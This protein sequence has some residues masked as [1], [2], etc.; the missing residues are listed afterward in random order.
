MQRTFFHTAFFKIKLTLGCILKQDKHYSKS[1]KDMAAKKPKS[2]LSPTALA[3]P[4]WPA[5]G[6][7]AAAIIVSIAPAAKPSA[8]IKQV[9]FN[10]PAPKAVRIE[11][12]WVLGFVRRATSDPMGDETALRAPRA[13]AQMRNCQEK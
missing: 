13:V 2:V 3:L 5:S 6:I 8:K 9:R 10:A 7:I 4:I 1:L 12:N 11:M